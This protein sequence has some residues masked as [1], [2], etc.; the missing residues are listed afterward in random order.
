VQQEW[1]RELAWRHVAA[2]RHAFD[3][4]FLHDRPVGAARSARLPGALTSLAAL[5]TLPAARGRG[6]GT[7]LLARMI[8]DARVAGSGT[9]F[10]AIVAGSYV[11]GMYD[12]LGFAPR[13]ETRTFTLPTVL[14]R[15]A[16]AERY[17]WSEDG[18][19]RI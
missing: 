8:E 1:D 2:G 6:V 11:A 14:D 15:A 7:S 13:F 12:R 16:P 10:G 18:P 9:I 19:Q 4:A 3:V 5:T 17:G